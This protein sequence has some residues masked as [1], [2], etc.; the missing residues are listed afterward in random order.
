MAPLLMACV[1]VLFKSKKSVV[2]AESP[3]AIF[4]YSEKSWNEAGARGKAD[5]IFKAATKDLLTLMKLDVSVW[6]Q[7]GDVSTSDPTVLFLHFP[8]PGQHVPLMLP[9]LWSS[10]S[11]RP[12]SSGAPHLQ[13][14]GAFR[15]SFSHTYF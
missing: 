11:S 12:F 1:F 10:F 6:A 4:R 9:A 8:C 13:V 3:S 7:K 5:T 14:D 2:L 15:P